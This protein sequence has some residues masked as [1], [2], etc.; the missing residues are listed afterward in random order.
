MNLGRFQE[1]STVRY[2][3][4][5]MARRNV[6]WA[7]Q[8]GETPACYVLDVSDGTLLASAIGLDANLELEP[9]VLAAVRAVRTLDEARFG[10]VLA[11][12]YFFPEEAGDAD[13]EAG[14]F[15]VRRRR[16]G[17]FMSLPPRRP[18]GRRMRA[19]G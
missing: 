11:D 16:A 14:V 1:G 10:S 15:L 12:V 3:P 6:L 2:S 18:A 4:A 5:E 9:E 19:G 8:E 7:Q 13:D 17:S